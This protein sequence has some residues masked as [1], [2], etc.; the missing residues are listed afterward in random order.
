MATRSMIGIEDTDGS[1]TAI[2]CHW[3][4]YIENGVGQMLV[5]HW[6]DIEKID[7]LMQLGSLSVLGKEIG[8]K[9]PFNGFK[10]REQCLAHGRDKGERDSKAL[11]Y[12]DLEAFVDA[13]YN[14]DYLYLFVG[15]NWLVYSW[16]L[17]WISVEDVLTKEVEYQ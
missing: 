15:E 16:H 1:V 7:Q 12:P 10:G 13:A 11:V 6:T 17:G 4:G 5:E 2:Y 8:T 9:V 14:V 3:D